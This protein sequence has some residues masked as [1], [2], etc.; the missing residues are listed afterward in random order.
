MICY[1]I[2]HGATHGNLEGRYVGRTDEPVLPLELKKLETLGKELEPVQCVFTSPYLRCRQ[3]AEA[4]FARQKR[5]F[6]QEIVTDFREMDFGEFEYKNY[7]ELNGNSAY[8]RFIDCGGV[9]SFPGGEDPRYFKERCRRAFQECI[10]QA[11]RQKWS[12][13]GFVLHGGTI[14]A[15]MEA[16][17]HPKRSYFE[18]QVKNGCGYAAKA[19]C[20]PSL[21]LVEVKKW[22]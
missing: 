21:Q 12:S 5:V 7:Q 2:R 16:W 13:L 11:Q 19:V 3:S 9:T 14:M 15:I 20:T 10:C 18:Y 1:Q 22:G 6:K 17:G 4:L 8:Q